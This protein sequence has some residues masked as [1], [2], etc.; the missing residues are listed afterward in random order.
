ML[1]TLR[2][3]ALWMV[4]LL[5]VQAGN[6]A[7]DERLGH[8]L[9]AKLESAES[10]R[11]PIIVRYNTV[12]TRTGIQSIQQ[13]QQ[14]RQR[15]KLAQ[16]QLRQEYA[17][18][19]TAIVEQVLDFN[20]V[21]MSAMRVNKQALLTLLND[22]SLTVYQDSLRRPL[23][24]QS[25]ARVYPTRNSSA[26]HGDNQWAVAV[27][28]TGTNKSHPNLANKV[29][30]EACYSGGNGTPGVSSLCP[31]GVASSTAVNSGAACAVAGCEHG[32]MVAG[33]AGGDEETHNGEARDGKLI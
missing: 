23:L 2:L 26:F 17:G 11:I 9:L 3:F 20:Y 5:L 12:Q 22:S 21:P 18:K 29:V 31:A 27:L 19:T 15:L 28:D 10:K 16:A 6:A 1:R 8:Q 32:S 13:A 24:T 7:S 25:V 33:T 30:S 4:S 14:D